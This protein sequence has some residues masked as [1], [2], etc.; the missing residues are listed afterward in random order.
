VIVDS[1]TTAASRLLDSALGQTAIITFAIPRQ[2]RS[3]CRLTGARLR[4]RRRS[5]QR[6]NAGSNVPLFSTPALHRLWH[7]S[8]CIEPDPVLLQ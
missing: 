8:H 5:E 3:S 1:P 2:P 4:R 7:R 6:A